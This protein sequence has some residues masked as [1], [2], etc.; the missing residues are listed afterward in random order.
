MT[1]EKKITIDEI[2]KVDV[3]RYNEISRFNVKNKNKK[4]VLKGK[5]Y[6][7]K[8]M[9]KKQKKEEK[10]KKK[11]LNIP[12]EKKEPKTIENQAIFDTNKIGVEN[13]NFLINENC[14]DEFS[15]YFKNKTEPNIVITSIKK[16]S[17]YTI[18]FIKELSF[19]F[20]NI[21]YE[22]RNN[23]SIDFLI[24][25]AIENKFTT[26][27]LIEEGIKKKPK[28]M[29][30]CTLPYGPTTKYTLTNISYAHTKTTDIEI[31]KLHPEVYISNFNT[32]IGE[33]IKRQLHTLVPYNPQYKGQKVVVFY[34]QRDFIF[35]RHYKYNFVNKKKCSL[36][37]IGPGFTLQLI[38]LK[39]FFFF[40]FSFYFLII[41]FH[42]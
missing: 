14:I 6:L 31:T 20:P 38:N 18:L 1:K 12:I 23:H 22:P 30:I 7:K 32:F 29:F 15:N 25:S 11:K 4:N 17:K 26:F 41:L 10:K 34:N 35:F 8:L 3:D 40:F 13:K 9:L 33:R 21:F 28:Y 19:V 37:E 39:V 5:V 42:F 27:I 36:T 16:A 2:E 24:S